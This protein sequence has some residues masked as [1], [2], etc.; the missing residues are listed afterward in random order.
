MYYVFD[1][2]LVN[3]LLIICC[4]GGVA[5]QPTSSGVFYGSAY[6][7]AV[8]FTSSLLCPA[9]LCLCSLPAVPHDDVKS[10]RT[11]C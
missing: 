11:F 3:I 6:E 9:P 7:G 5:W 10:A 1:I 2:Y 8:L 4:I